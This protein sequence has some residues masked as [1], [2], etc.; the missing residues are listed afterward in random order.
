MQ[1]KGRYLPVAGFDND[2][3]MKEFLS[4]G[5]LVATVDIFSSQMAVRGIEFA[6]NVLEGK[7]ENEGA[8][9]TAHTII[10]Q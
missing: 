9:T 6:L 3:A 7:T 10:V 5:R 2:A 1:E 8:C 4:T